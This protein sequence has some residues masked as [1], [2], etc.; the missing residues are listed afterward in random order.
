[1]LAAAFRRLLRCNPVTYLVTLAATLALVLIVVPG[2][3]RQVPYLQSAD[4]WEEQCKV[5][6]AETDEQIKNQPPE[7]FAMP[8]TQLYQHGWPRPY[9]ARTV[10]VE[11][12]QPY[13][14]SMPLLTSGNKI[15]GFL[16]PSYLAD[17]VSWSNYDN[18]PLRSAAWRIHPWHFLLDTF[19]ILI[20][21]GG[22]GFV[23]EWW[24]RSRG[25]LFRFRIVDLLVAVTVCGLLLG[26]YKHHENLTRIEREVAE[27]FTAGSPNGNRNFGSKTYAGPVWLRKLAGDDNYL[28]FLYH[29]TYA[30]WW[31]DE[32]NWAADV[33]QF[34]RLPR[35]EN[36]WVTLP[37][38]QYLVTQLSKT[39]R[40]QQ[41]N[42]SVM[43]AHQ[44]KQYA[45]VEGHSDPQ[46][47][48]IGNLDELGV[49][50]LKKITLDVY[51]ALAPDIE[52]MLQTTDVELLYLDG[53][54]ITPQE[55]E[56][57][58]EKFPET[59]VTIKWAIHHRDTPPENHAE[60]VERT[61]SNRGR[62]GVSRP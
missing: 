43:P 25:G 35:L 18:W 42:I 22:A 38:P 40:L 29:T 48:D 12:F 16:G 10:K 27:Y 2:E 19:V 34:V 14:Y 53:V 46:L 45:A 6:A 28:P 15:S 61:K 62:L 41:L 24:L 20:L 37:I 50:K 60:R 26:W 33:D 39:S 3:Q 23:T 11:A 7:K 51:D 52:R 17:F 47:I 9:L 5:V 30:R 21:V 13:K 54:A 59:A 58:R 49:L 44:H 32:N 57:L 36:V 31:P 4:W 56:S 1:M 55:L 8:T